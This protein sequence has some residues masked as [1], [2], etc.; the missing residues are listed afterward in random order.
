MAGS[1]LN[2][3]D[4]L[5]FGLRRVFVGSIEMPERPAI[6]CGWGITATD[7]PNTNRT[8]LSVVSADNTIEVGPS[9]VRVPGAAGLLIK[10]QTWVFTYTALQGLADGVISYDLIS[11][12]GIPAGSRYAGYILDLGAEWDDTAAGQIIAS[13]GIGL[14][15][16]AFASGVYIHTAVGESGPAFPTSPTDGNVMWFFGRPLPP[17]NVRINIH[18]ASGHDLNDIIA[19]SLSVTIFYF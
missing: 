16:T 11:A 9:G 8:V 19:G 14:D 12:T 18:N 6:Q 7:D 2:W 4:A 15:A 13:V 3:M 17:D 10:Q 5:L 1:M